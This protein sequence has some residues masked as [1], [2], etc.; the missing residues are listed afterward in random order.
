MVTGG[1]GS[2]AVDRAYGAWDPVLMGRS[3]GYS[4][5]LAPGTV[6]KSS[7]ERLGPDIRGFGDLPEK[8][9]V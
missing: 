1:S 6:R 4:D 7:P 3:W 8:G 9:P 2:R 5:A